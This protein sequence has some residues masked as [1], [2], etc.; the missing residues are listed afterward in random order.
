MRDEDKSHPIQR[1]RE[2]IYLFFAVP[3][4]VALDVFL[5]VTGST[6]GRVMGVIFAFVI[7]VIV[8]QGRRARQARRHI[9]RG[10]R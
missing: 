3:V 2:W 8:I 10:R 4:Y 7:A 5:L 9:D 6:L 1:F